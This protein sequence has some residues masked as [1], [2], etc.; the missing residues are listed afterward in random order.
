MPEEKK[1][2][3][4]QIKRR[5]TKYAMAASLCVLVVSGFQK[6]KTARTVHT[7]AGFALIGL[8]AY[9]TALYKKRS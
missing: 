3:P 7:A 2:S 9:H 6:G 1:L 5:Y 4:L 8:A